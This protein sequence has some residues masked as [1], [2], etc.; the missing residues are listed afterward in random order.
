MLAKTTHILH[1]II[2]LHKQQL[3]KKIYYA[4]VQGIIKHITI[5]HSYLNKNP[6]YKTHKYHQ[7]QAVMLK[8]K[9]LVTF[10]HTHTTLIKKPYLQ[11]T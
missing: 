4:Q 6:T 1:Q 7:T 11:N 5:H 9:P 10:T 2:K 8:I 3:I